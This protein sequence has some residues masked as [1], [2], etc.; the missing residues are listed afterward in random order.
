MSQPQGT[1]VRESKIY[2]KQQKDS[3]LNL[4]YKNFLWL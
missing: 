3:E 4:L 1:E 2:V